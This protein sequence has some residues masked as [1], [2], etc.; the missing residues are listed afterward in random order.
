MDFLTELPLSALYHVHNADNLNN[1]PFI[2]CNKNVLA[3]TILLFIY[4]LLLH[5]I[6]LGV[7][8][9]AFQSLPF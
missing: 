6:L 1:H 8:Q 5:L 4:E 9:F 3:T 2:L 7:I